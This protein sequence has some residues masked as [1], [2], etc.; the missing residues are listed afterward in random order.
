IGFINT[1][2]CSPA[3]LTIGP[4]REA[5]VGCS[6][7]YGSPPN[8]LNQSTV[9]DYV[10]RTIAAT[11]LQ[12]GGSDQVWYDRGSSHYYLAAR[13]NVDNNNKPMPV[14]GVVD[15]RGNVYDGG[16]PS[17]ISAHSV[18]A[19]SNNLYVFLPIGFVAAGASDPT[20]PCPTTGCIAVYQPTNLD[21]DDIAFNKH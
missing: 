3:G 16:E 12:V 13:N 15:A 1:P 2:F 7:K 14:L 17:S 19:N 11:I 10:D 4:R 20:N 21:R 9:I 5:M 6:A 18:A 8:V